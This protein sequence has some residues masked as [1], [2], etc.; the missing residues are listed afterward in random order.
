MQ[1]YD[2]RRG[3]GNVG[4]RRLTWFSRV[5][6]WGGGGGSWWGG[7][8]GGDGRS[9]VAVLRAA[10]GGLDALHPPSVPVALVVRL[11]LAL[12][13]RGRW[14]GVSGTALRVDIAGAAGGE[15]ARGRLMENTRVTA[16][17]VMPA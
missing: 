4:G 12:P 2:F 15:G 14:A 6:V 5:S 7:R 13:E 10:L 1:E 8:G 17:A 9:L 3:R 11:G 16:D